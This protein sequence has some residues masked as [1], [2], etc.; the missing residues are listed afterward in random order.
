MELHI[1]IYQ[2]KIYQQLQGNSQMES[3]SPNADESRKFWSDIWDNRKQH[4]KR[5]EWLE[6]L[7]NNKSSV[8]QND[9]EITIRMVKQ[10]VKKIPSWKAPGPD[11]VQGF[12]VKKLTSLHERIATQLNDLITNVKEIPLWMTTGKT[13]LCQKAR[14]RGMQ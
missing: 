1:Y 11:G 4:N 14:Q 2:Q 5:A 8:L 10:Q 6:K 7:R 9:I 13:V 3:Q 12:W